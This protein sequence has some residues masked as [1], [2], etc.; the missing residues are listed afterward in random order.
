MKKSILLGA[1]LLSGCA[2]IFVEPAS[3][4]CETAVCRAEHAHTLVRAFDTLNSPAMDAAIKA[5]QQ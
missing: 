1:V 3:I 4:G 5:A 2:S